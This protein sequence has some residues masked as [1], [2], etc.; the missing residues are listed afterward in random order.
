MAGDQTEKDEVERCVDND[1]TVLTDEKRS[2]FSLGLRYESYNY[3]NDDST[4]QDTLNR[5]EQSSRQAS[6]S[7]L[8]ITERSPS[9]IL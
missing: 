5:K 3:F 7:G 6:Q 4:S 8:S 9:E 2:L 1:T